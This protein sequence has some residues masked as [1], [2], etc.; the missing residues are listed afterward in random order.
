MIELKMEKEKGGLLDIS[1]FI[2]LCRLS[3]QLS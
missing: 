2:F 3:V 1:P